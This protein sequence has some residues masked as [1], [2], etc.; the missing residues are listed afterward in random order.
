MEIL[1]L[2]NQN[3]YGKEFLILCHTPHIY[4]LQIVKK[5]KK[6]S[7]IIIQ[8]EQNKLNLSKQMVMTH[9]NK[10]SSFFIYCDKHF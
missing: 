8:R 6:I 2:Y 1:I 5:K 3:L 10:W 9:L 4:V 7:E